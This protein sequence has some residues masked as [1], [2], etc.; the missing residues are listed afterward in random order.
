MHFVEAGKGQLTWYL[1]LKKLVSNVVHFMRPSFERA[2]ASRSAPPAGRV[3]ERQSIC[4][5]E[6]AFQ[7]AKSW[8]EDGILSEHGVAE[9]QIPCPRL[10]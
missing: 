5:M 4:T 3:E 6:K 7:F 1:P 9:T 2:K 10:V 8:G